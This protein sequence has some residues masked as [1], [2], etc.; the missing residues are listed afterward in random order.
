M[1][2]VLRKNER[3][4]SPGN[5]RGIPRRDKE[6]GSHHEN[7]TTEINVHWEKTNKN[8]S[9]ALTVSMSNKILLFCYR[10]QNQIYV[11]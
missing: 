10:S 6:S 8:W 3:K 4:G 11:K 1:R 5:S 2:H 9:A 7:S